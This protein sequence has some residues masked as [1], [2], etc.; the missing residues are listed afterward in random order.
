M[1]FDNIDD[2]TKNM[3]NHMFGDPE[4]RQRSYEE[5]EARK[6]AEIVAC[7]EAELDVDLARLL[8]PDDLYAVLHNMCDLEELDR[9]TAK[10]ELILSLEAELD[11]NSVG[12]FGI[13]MED[14]YEKL[15]DMLMPNISIVS[16]D[17]TLQAVDAI[18]NAAHEGL[19]GGGGID[20]AIHR[21][22]GPSLLGECL[23]LPKNA[24]GDRCPTGAVRITSGYDLTCLY[25]LHTVG[26]VWRG[27]NH[28]E[29]ERLIDCYVSCLEMASNQGLHSIAFPC[30]ST[31]A[32]CYPK[33][34]AARTAIKTVDS[35]CLNNLTSLRDVRFVCFDEDNMS[36]YTS[37]MADFSL[38]KDE[39]S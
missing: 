35:W 33:R 2:N 37:A 22:A 7:P 11:E 17:L 8:G 10:A 36:E 24:D 30:I 3:M 18:V 26:P 4:D 23:N 9:K 28:D 39:D 38:N 15:S 6:L 29:E 27:G 1:D 25:I 19:T 20:G 13:S 32:F 21:G 5:E 16:G 14:D 31:G 12:N 34:E